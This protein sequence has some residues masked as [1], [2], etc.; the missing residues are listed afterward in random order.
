MTKPVFKYSKLVF[1][2]SAIL[3]I[4]LLIDICTACHLVPLW[5]AWLLFT[6]ICGISAVRLWFGFSQKCYKFSWGLIGQ[7]ILG[8]AVLTFFQLSYTNV[9]E[10]PVSHPVTPAV[11][12]IAPPVIAHDSIPKSAERY[13]EHKFINDKHNISDKA[14]NNKNHPHKKASN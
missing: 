9:I 3:T 8:G 13:P 4:P 2:I 7:L 5:I 10:T 12:D 14:D 1:A 6:L 11:V